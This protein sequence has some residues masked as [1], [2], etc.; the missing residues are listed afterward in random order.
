MQFIKLI[1]RIASIID[2]D[3]FDTDRISSQ[4]NEKIF[5]IAQ[6]IEVP[7][8][9]NITSPLTFLYA[10]AELDLLSAVRFVALPSDYQRGVFN[11]HDSDAETFPAMVSFQKFIQKYPCLETGDILEACVVHGASLFYTPSLDKTVTIHYYKAPDTLVNGTDELS[12]IPEHLQQRLIVNGVCKDIFAEIEDGLDGRKVNTEYHEKI[13]Y[14]AV[15]ALDRFLGEDG[16]PE[17]IENVGD[18]IQ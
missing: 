7:G 13:F 1:E 4:I 6:G 3:F 9:V 10:T 2:D 8:K 5:E 16:V 11:I 15:A 17:Y 14:Q 18:Y 12:C